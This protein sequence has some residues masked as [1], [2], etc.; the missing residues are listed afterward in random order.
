[1]S[2]C[3]PLCDCTYDWEMFY[4]N[5]LRTRHNIKCERKCKTRLSK[6]SKTLLED[7]FECVCNQPSLQVIEELAKF[8][9]VKKEM[10]Y[11]WFTNKRRKQKGYKRVKKENPVSCK[12]DVVG[13]G[14]HD[15]VLDGLDQG[16]KRKKKG[17]GDESHPS[18]RTMSN[19]RKINQ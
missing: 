18:G 10:V 9:D 19:T 15:R 14:S 5:H 6:K 17:S 12:Q 13:E 1:M 2:F 7:Y 8:I 3:C 16:R 11:W 4:N